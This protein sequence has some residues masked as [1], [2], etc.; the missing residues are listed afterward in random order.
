MEL[1]GKPILRHV[2]ERCSDV[3]GIDVVVCA[4]PEGL[5]N[6]AV[7]EI[8]RSCGV[9]VFRGSEHDVLARYIGAARMVGA[10]T[11]LRVTSDCPLIDPDVCGRVLT[12]LVESGADYA[13]NVAPRSF[14][15]GLDCE[16][17]HVATLNEA[18]LSPLAEDHEHVTPWHRKAS[19]VARVNVLSGR[20]DLADLRWTLDFPEDFA[21]LRAVFARLPA[22]R[23]T[24][25][26]DVLAVL[27]AHPELAEIN[28]NRL[29]TQFIASW[30]QSKQ[31]HA[32]TP[33]SP[34]R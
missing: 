19:H 11:V 10:D 1:A 29:E 6:D 26:D 3:P 23:S 4:V 16:A 2:L 30:K 32:E 17:F 9:V 33:G 25:M 12:R 8:A 18:A 34:P 7:A 24:R 22:A 28:A 31:P 13:S 21:F 15:H 27:S 20:P 14:P 5:M